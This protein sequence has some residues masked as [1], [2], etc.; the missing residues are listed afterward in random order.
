MLTHLAL[1]ILILQRAPSDVSI[2]RVVKTAESHLALVVNA[3]VIPI[4]GK[5]ESP[6][7]YLYRVET[8]EFTT[9]QHVY[10]WGVTEWHDLE[11]ENGKH[12]E[13]AEYHL[14][15]DPTHP[16]AEIQR[17]NYLSFWGTRTQRGQYTEFRIVKLNGMTPFKTPQVVRFSPV[18]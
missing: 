17:P 8:S 15:I 13:L 14:E 1:P 12:Y 4:L 16:N 2:A 18:R 5:F 6:D 10:I 9:L 3:H 11:D 7:G